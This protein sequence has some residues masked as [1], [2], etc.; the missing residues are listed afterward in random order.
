M[1]L[2]QLYLFFGKL[3]FVFYITSEV[4][5]YYRLVQDIVNQA[6]RFERGYYALIWFRAV[7]RL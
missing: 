1:I 3:F 7:W 4:V 5:M 6:R 2:Y